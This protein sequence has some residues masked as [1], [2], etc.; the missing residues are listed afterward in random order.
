MG[1]Y[2][3]ILVEFGFSADDSNLVK[4]LHSLYRKYGYEVE[5]VRTNEDI[6]YEDACEINQKCF[7][8][9]IDF[10]EWKH[11]R[12]LWRGTLTSFMETSP[13]IKVD[14]NSKVEKY[15]S[16]IRR[17]M[18]LFPE[19]EVTGEVLNKLLE[20]VKDLYAM[21]IVYSV[22]IQKECQ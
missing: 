5:W 15:Y 19:E 10:E 21:D 18:I 7:N 20:L 16:A 14:E 6:S 11:N 9:R 4:D 1:F 3:T 13:S 17:E 2:F 12:M 22:Q 8:E